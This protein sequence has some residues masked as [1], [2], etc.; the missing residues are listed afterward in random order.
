MNKPVEYLIEQLSKT[1]I[2]EMAYSRE[3]Y[4]DNIDDI[5]D[6]IVENWCL[7][8]YCTLYDK[9]NKNKAHWKQE[10]KSYCKKL[11]RS[12]VKVN[13]LKATQDAMIEMLELDN[14]KIVE[15]TIADKFEKENF[16]IKQDICKDF[17]EYGLQKIIYLV[18]KKFSNTSYQELYRYIDEDI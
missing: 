7:I 13:K 10:L 5:A 6:Q 14:Q 15:V 16:E 4:I 17:S 11:L 1:H 18:S 12:V 2:F 9:D 8:H 3:Q